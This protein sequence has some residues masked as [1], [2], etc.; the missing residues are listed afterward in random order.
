MSSA[1]YLIVFRRCEY[2]FS[3]L[4]LQHHAHVFHVYK[5]SSLRGQ[6]DPPSE[7]A[8]IDLMAVVSPIC[9]M[10]QG[11]PAI[12]ICMKQPYG[13]LMYTDYREV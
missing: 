1:Q 8:S 12:K 4:R 11:G 6:D 7:H 5:G 3:G 9:L 13:G 10:L 2:P